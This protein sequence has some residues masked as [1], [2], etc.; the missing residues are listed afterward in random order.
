MH[1]RK[2]SDQLFGGRRYG[3][4]GPVHWPIR[5]LNLTPMEKISNVVYR[6][7]P[8]TSQDLK[9]RIVAVCVQSAFS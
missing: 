2:I 1:N 8:I 9:Y 3:E 5:T 6:D 7:V 4:G